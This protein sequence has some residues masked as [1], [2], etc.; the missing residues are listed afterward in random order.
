MRLTFT[1]KILPSDS[2]DFIINTLFSFET[3]VEINY[4]NQGN[5]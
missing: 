5:P 3:I 1:F 2:S 4:I